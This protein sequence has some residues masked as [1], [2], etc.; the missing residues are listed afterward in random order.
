VLK[1]VEEP[2]PELQPGK[3]LVKVLAAGVAFADVL[4]REG[5]YSDQPAYPFTPGYDVMGIVEKVQGS[6][7]FQPGLPVLALTKIGGYAEYA[8]IPEG[9]LVQALPGVDPAQAVSLVLNYLTA[10]QMLHRIARVATGD[11]ILVH[12]AAGG[13]GTALLELGHLAGLEMFG[14]ASR[15]KHDLVQKLGA[16]PIDYRAEDFVERIRTLTGDGVDVVLDPVGGSH[17]NRS[18]ATLRGGGRLI[19]YGFAAATTDG[20]R[21]LLK[22]ALNWLRMLRQSPLGMMEPNRAI[23]GFNVYTLKTQ[24]PEWYHDDLTALIHLLA[25]GKIQPVIA[26]RLPL[27][28]AARAQQL[29]GQ[30]AVQGKLVLI[31]NPS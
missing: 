7:A 27:T 2:L 30:S 12:G 26:E 9:S 24:R 10:Y 25:D 22:G 18:Y 8:T 6:S 20:R 29:L 4:M 21:N 19:G 5:L 31:C 3:V 23:M 13:V 17:W 14:T 16:T 1:V 28:E 11:R 15:A